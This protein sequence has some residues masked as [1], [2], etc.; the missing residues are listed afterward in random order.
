ML[1]RLIITLTEKVDRQL[2]SESCSRMRLH[3]KEVR[4]QPAL[5]WSTFYRCSFQLK[6]IFFPSILGFPV[7][8][9][10]P[11]S[12]LNVVDFWSRCSSE[13]VSHEHWI[14]QIFQCRQTLKIQLTRSSFESWAPATLFWYFSRPEDCRQRNSIVVK[15][16]I[17][18]LFWLKI[19]L[20][21]VLGSF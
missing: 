17:F 7:H 15:I 9:W 18:L 5:S 6:M 8:Q 2:H 1:S 11:F 16:Q 4:L 12:C 20:L 19:N 13:L 21:G 3:T 10:V 14:E